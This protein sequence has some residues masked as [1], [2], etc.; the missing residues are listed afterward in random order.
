MFHSFPVNA[1]FRR[2]LC[3]EIIEEK[4]KLNA[5]GGV[6]SLYD[7]LGIARRQCVISVAVH[8]LLLPHSQ[9]ARAAAHD[10]AAWYGGQSGISDFLTSAGHF[11]YYSCRCF[12]I[13][14]PRL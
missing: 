8:R 12:G 6:E 1:F 10:Q 13:R 9:R 14:S 5:R 7:V 2:D 3:R 11:H 4:K